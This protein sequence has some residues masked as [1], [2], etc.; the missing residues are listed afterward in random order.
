MPLVAVLY[1]QRALAFAFAAIESLTLALAHAYNIYKPTGLAS[2]TP[3]WSLSRAQTFAL[4][5]NEPARAAASYA[6]YDRSIPRGACVGALFGRNAP[7]YPLW[8]AGL[9][10]RVVYLPRVRSAAA[11][12]AR[13]LRTVVVGAAASAAS[14][15]GRPGWSVDRWRAGGGSRPVP[16][17]PAAGLVLTP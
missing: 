14:F 11:A 8:D 6:R 2:T 10:R 3:V 13:G 4:T 15:R 17:L 12:E 7:L 16:A 9:R 1:R 5:A